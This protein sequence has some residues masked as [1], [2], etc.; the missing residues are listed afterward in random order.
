MCAGMRV[1]S[2]FQ[3]IRSFIGARSPIRYSP[4]MRDHSRSLERS[5][6]KAPT[7]CPAVR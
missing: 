7:I 4:T 3:A 2:A 5:N 1:A 6:W